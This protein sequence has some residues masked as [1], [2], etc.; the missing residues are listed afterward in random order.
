MIAQYIRKINICVAVKLFAQFLRKKNHN[1]HA[2]SKSGREHWEPAV[3]EYFCSMV[4]Y[5]IA[6]VSEQQ[7]YVSFNLFVYVNE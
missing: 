3:K 7:K 1:K 2:R 6:V 4:F 5:R